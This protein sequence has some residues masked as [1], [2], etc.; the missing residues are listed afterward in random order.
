MTQL[1]QTENRASFGGQQ[2]IWTHH[3][4]TLNCDMN[5]AVYLPPQA[6]QG[7]QCPTLY[8]L[9]G[10]TCTERNFIEKSGFQRYAAEHGI[11]VVAPDTSPRGEAVANDDAYDLGQGAGFYLNATQSPW[12]DNYQMYD[13]IT[14]ELPTLIHDNFA[15][16]VNGKQ[17]ISG[18]SMGGHG[19]LMIALR[20][21]EKFASVS[22]FAPIVAPTQAPWGK[23]AFNHY[24]GDNPADWQQYD[25]TELLTNMTADEIAKLPPMLI[26]QGMSDEFLAQLQPEM[27]ETVAKDKGV[28]LTLNRQQGYDHSYYFI[29]SFIGEH[30]EFHANK[31]NALNS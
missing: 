8:W 31:L 30:L 11:I 3:S 2:Q 7:K 21:P 20:N 29:A 14:E 22:A 24:L 23:K 6:L 13:Y 9:S 26:D 16:Y 12:A 17:S 18:H 27:F 19:A 1:T 10:L 4:T 28:N 5:L 25:S 15:Q